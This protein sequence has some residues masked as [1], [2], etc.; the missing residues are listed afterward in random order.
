MLYSPYIGNRNG[1]EWR[2]S[3]TQNKNPPTSKTQ[4]GNSKAKTAT[5]E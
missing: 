5:G 2:A 1:I 3:E 4:N